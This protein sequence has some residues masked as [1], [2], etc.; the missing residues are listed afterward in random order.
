ML[1][2]LVSNDKLDVYMFWNQSKLENWLMMFR[3]IQALFQRDVFSP[4]KRLAKLKKASMLLLNTNKNIDN[5][6]YSL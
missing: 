1:L 4:T 5:I 2:G 3:E 6:T